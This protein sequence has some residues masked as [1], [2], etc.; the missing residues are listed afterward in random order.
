LYVSPLNL[1]EK[2]IWF[3]EII[4]DGS[5]ALVFLMAAS[6]DDTAS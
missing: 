5:D 6:G 4:D 2:M 1:N 3:S